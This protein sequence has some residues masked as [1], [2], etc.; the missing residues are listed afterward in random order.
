LKE[1]R[2]VDAILGSIAVP[3]IFPPK[4]YE[5]YRLVDGGT[6]NPV[7]VSAARALAP[8][9]PVVAVTL[10]PPLD[11][12]STPI[13]L[14]IPGPKPLLDQLSRLN[15]TQAFQIF[16]ES[17]DIGQRKMTEMCLKMERPEVLIAPDTGD[18]GLLD[19]VDVAEVA[20]QGETAAL[21]A[22]PDLRYALSWRARLRRFL[23][24]R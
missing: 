18:I 21:A 5:P 1:G 10:Y 20:K 22:W 14:L 13:N 15:I 11:Q 8:N 17:I 6:L 16:A 3:G 9:L 23:R 4:D 19:T 2:V 24:R 7:P 12:P